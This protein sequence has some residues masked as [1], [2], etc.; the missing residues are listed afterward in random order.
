MRIK[1]FNKQTGVSIIEIVIA[2]TIIA[3]IATMAVTQLG[4]AKTQFQRENV[5]RAFKNYLE[6]ARFDSVKRRAA[7]PADMAR[8]VINSATSFTSRIDQN[9]NGKLDANEQNEVSFSGGSDVR[10]YGPSTNFPITLRFDQR[11]YL[12]ATDS[13]GAVINPVFSICNGACTTSTMTNGNSNIVS[14]SPT[15]T[16]AMN[17]G[18]ETPQT[19]SDPTV[20][21]VSYEIKKEV[22][23]IDSSSSTPLPTPGYTPTPTPIATPTPT[24]TAT[25]V[26]TPTPTPP[27]NACSYGD[28]PNKI[29]TCVCVAPMT[30]RKSGKCQ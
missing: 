2:V 4:N 20:G 14:I 26:P 19:F 21:N 16:V 3:V 11:G 29:P 17:A 12:I 18:G 24:P 13:T 7:N 10:L 1:E 6:R 30:V 5:A 25:P 8:V 9:Q 27:P 23:V 22:T 15:G 28:R